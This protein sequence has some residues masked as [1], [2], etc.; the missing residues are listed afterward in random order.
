VEVIPASDRDVVAHVL[1]TAFADDPVIRWV[2][3]DPVDDRTFFTA[4]LRHELTDAVL[5]LAVVDGRPI[6]AAVW[7]RPGQSTAQQPG[8]DELFIEIL[9]M[10]G[11][12]RAGELDRLCEEARPAEPHWYLADLGAAE[13][14][15]GAGGALLR[16]GLDRV[17]GPAYLESSNEVNIPIYERYGFAVT[18]VIE[19][20]DGPKLW[21][22]YRPG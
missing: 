7:Q 22:M 4:V 6:G 8:T 14:G 1:A 15:R 10:A 19:V 21:T 9:G 5:D 12:V 18:G 17:D 3:A 2:V 11:A 13:P 16:A 20:P